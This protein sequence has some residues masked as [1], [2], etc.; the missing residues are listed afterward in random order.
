MQQNHLEGLWKRTHVGP[1][2][3]DSDSRGL[4]WGLRIS[5]SHSSQATMMLMLLVL[6]ATDSTLIETYPYSG[7]SNMNVHRS[8]LGILWYTCFF[9]GSGVEPEVLCFCQAPASMSKVLEHWREYTLLV[10]IMKILLINPLS[11]LCIQSLSQP[12]SIYYSV[13]VVPV[14]PSSLPPSCPPLP[15]SLLSFILSSNKFPG[16]AGDLV[17]GTYW[18]LR[19]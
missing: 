18:I 1:T 19:L 5:T 10:H 13:V 3:R 12:P 8:H 6:C 11:S 14:A 15:P 4:G 16:D 9:I 7:F 2:L 17:C